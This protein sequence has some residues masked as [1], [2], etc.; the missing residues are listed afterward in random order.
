MGIFSSSEERELI[1]RL[2]GSDE[3]AFEQIYFR[4]VQKAYGFAYHYLKNVTEAEEVIQEVFTK[5]WENRHN[6]NPDMSFNGYLL[7]SVK[8]AIFNENRKKMYHRTYVS[9]VL[10]YLQTHVKNTEE[11]ITY[12]ELEKIIN[13]TIELMPPKRQE[14]FRLCRIEG[15]SHKMISETLGIAEKTIET[16]IRLA[17]KEL[18]EKLSPLIDRIL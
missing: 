9:E 6:I 2:I 5:I 16:H 8:N 12:D 13:K 10:Q 17:L 1:I 4:Y 18:R 3:S 14:I 15:M 11:Q 7:T